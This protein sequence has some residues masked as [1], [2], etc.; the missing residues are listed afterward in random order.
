MAT[1]S[2]TGGAREHARSQAGQ[3]VRASPTIPASDAKDLPPGVEPA[4]V[5]WDETIAAGEYA[6][7]ILPRYSRLRL[8]D[9]EGEGSAGFLA[10]NG[11]Q[12]IERLNV[13]DTV[14]VQWQAY[15]GAGSLLLSDM[16]RVLMS[17]THDSCGN[18]DVFCGT[19]S[20]QADAERQGGGGLVAPN[21]RDQFT[22]ALSKHGLG[23]R[24]L[25]GNVNF[26][27]GVRI[28]P[29]GTLAWVPEASNPG[30][31]VEL[32]AEMEVLVVVVNTRHVLD[33]RA[34]HTVT[35]VRLVA[36][37]GLPT[38]EDDPCREAGPEAMRA[39][40]NTEDHLLG[41]GDPR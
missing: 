17:I 32:R 9:L 27:R 16:G 5:V 11:R 38:P 29:D 19:S 35:D 22:L 40:L 7:R 31:V 36:Y 8:V 2:T 26:F 1:T 41:H 34:G 37:Q 12:P 39:Y 4:E 18:H 3:R 15:L 20:A 21:G 30:A 6:S 28:A 13:A 24:D 23:R 33:P 14:K 10:F 25:P